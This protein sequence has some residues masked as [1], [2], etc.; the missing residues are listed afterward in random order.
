MKKFYFI[1]AALL[2]VAACDKNG[3]GNKEQDGP[4]TEV[5]YAGETYKVITL[6]DGSVWMAE[7]L[8]YVP[9]GKKVSEDAA[10][11]AGIWYPYEVKDGAAVVL[12]D[13]ASIKEYGY[14]YDIETALGVALNAD[15]FKSFEGAKGICPEGWHIPTRAD[16]FSILGYAQ[17]TGDIESDETDKTAVFYDD[18]AKGATVFNLMKEDTFNLKVVGYRN[19][20]NGLEATVGKYVVTPL[21]GEA[22]CADENFYGKPTMGYYLA[23][24]GHNSSLNADNSLKNLQFFAAMTMFSPTYTNGRVTCGYNNY[25]NGGPIRCVKDAK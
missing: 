7:N 6:A 21:T 13:E 17:K 10:E 14:L 20:I 24:T 18:K 16:W 15:N 2:A 22:N 25:C 12:K 4:I 23:S 9:E 3:N 19:R 5:T 1:A 11:N 8:R